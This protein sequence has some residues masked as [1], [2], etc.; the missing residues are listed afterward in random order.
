MEEERGHWEG[1][2]RERESESEREE[3]KGEKEE[4]RRVG[5]RRRK[6]MIVEDRIGRL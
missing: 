2:V 5:A 6:G 3:W 1:R 4:G